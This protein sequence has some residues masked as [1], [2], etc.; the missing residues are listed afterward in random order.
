VSDAK[1]KIKF[2]QYPKGLMAE[3]GFIPELKGMA[4][5]FRTG[6]GREKDT[7]FLQSLL[8]KFESGGELPEHYS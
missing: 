4:K 3:P 8:L 7:K 1:G 5:K 6:E 2:F